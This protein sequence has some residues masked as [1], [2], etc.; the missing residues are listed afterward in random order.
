MPLINLDLFSV[1]VA[2]AATGVLGFTVFLSGRKSI[3]H[4]TF[5]AFS[6]ITIAWGTINYFSYNITSASIAFWLLRGVIFFAVLQAFLIFQLFYVFP[7]TRVVFPKPYVRYLL[8][9][10]GATALLTLTPLVFSRV[11]EVSAAGRILRLENG[12]GI[13]L[14]GAVSVGLVAASVALLIRKT[15][16]S[17]GDERLQFKYLLLGAFLMFALIIAFNFILPA[18]LGNVRFIPLG[19]VF[20]FPFALFTSYAIAKHHLLHVKVVATEILTFILA[21]VMFIEVVLADS[22]LLIVFRS[23]V[24]LLVLIFGILLIR[25]VLREVEQREK[26]EEL[27]RQLKTANDQLGELSRFKTQLLSLAS[28]QIKSPLA[29]IKG[30]VSILL[31]GLYGSVEGQVRVTLEKVKRSTDN[32]VDLINTLLDLRK[33]EEGKM[34]Y[35]FERTD[36]NRLVGDTVE[37]LRPL[38][39]AKKLGMKFVPLAGAVL[40]QADAQK[41][42]QVVQNLIDNAIKYTPLGLVKVELQKEGAY[43]VC[44]VT[45]SGLGVPGDLLPHLFEEFVRDE[46]VKAKVLGMGLGLYIAKKIVE[47]HGG[48]IWAKSAGEKQGSQF[49][50]R[51]PLD[52]K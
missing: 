45:D 40:V 19:A 49:S 6:L 15:L 25:S 52:S 16:R 7:K 2:A 13:L 1:G 14:F 4:Q 51:L 35:R 34:E 10:V 38:A 12:P 41:L 42:K 46:R 30:F 26:L 20:T 21:V 43:V 23:G 18:F 36:L 44:S 9:V 29:A 48:A 27:A 8:P 50:F 47:A 33:V 28:H 3:T 11:L 39:E 31:D 24:L 22:L 5:L 37:E 32:L 17:A